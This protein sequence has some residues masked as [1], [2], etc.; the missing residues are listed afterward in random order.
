M[1]IDVKNKHTG[2]IAAPAL[3][4]NA[5]MIPTIIRTNANGFATSE[6]I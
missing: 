2:F 5:E 1:Q 4:E 3:I 6:I